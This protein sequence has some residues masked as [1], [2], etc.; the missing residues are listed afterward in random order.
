MR[1]LTDKFPDLG[2]IL[3]SLTIQYFIVQ[4]IVARAWPTHYSWHKNTISDLGNTTCG[5]FQSR[6]V[7]SPS[8]IMMNA[9]F[10]TLGI[11]MVV[12]SLLIYHEFRRTHSSKLGFG[13]MGLCGAG[14]VLVGLYPENVNLTLHNTGAIL[15][16]IGGGLALVVLG[17]NLALPSGLHR[18]TM[19]SAAVSLFAMLFFLTHRYFGLGIGGMERVAAYPQTIWIF[20][21]GIYISMQRYRVKHGLL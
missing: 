9:S 16:L 17:R 4:F 18:Y 10:I 7:C 15:A 20:V 12:G 5:T 1:I 11:A 6:Y 19:L 2:P 21:F 3:W 13:L 14:S 8:H